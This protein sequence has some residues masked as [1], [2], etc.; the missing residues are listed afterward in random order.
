MLP[1]E[2]YQDAGK[3]ELGRPKSGDGS[4]RFG[5][6]PP[7][8]LQCGER[9]VYC[10]RNLASSY[11]SWLDISVDHVVPKST[12]W[13]SRQSQWIEDIFNL[14]TCCRACNEFLN[15]YECTEPEP[16]CVA[17]FT[18]IRDATFQR[19]REKALARHAE[20]KGRYHEWRQDF[21][22]PAT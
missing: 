17:D 5:Y 8:F 18:T 1:F 10:D 21:V 11:D 16:R 9:C 14:V 19:K 15:Q 4:C 20:E 2:K 12:P 13:A 3:R 6:G 22:R 7:V